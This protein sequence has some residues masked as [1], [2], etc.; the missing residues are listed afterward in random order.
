MPDNGKK[1]IS[2]E[3]RLLIAFL[4]MGV[5]LFVMPYFYKQP[6][7]QP[8]TKST[9]PVPAQTEQAKQPAPAPTPQ[10]AAPAQ[11]AQAQ[12]TEPVPGA[13]QASAEQTFDIETD[14]YKVTFTNRGASVKAWIL[15]D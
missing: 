3:V 15:K 14:V 10:Q 8:A 6:P 13:T 4:L 9:N 12:P 2:M 7:E 11:P 5:V 1:E